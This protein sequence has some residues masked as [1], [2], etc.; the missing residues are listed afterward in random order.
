M[1][2]RRHQPRQQAAPARSSSPT[3]VFGAPGPH[4]HPAARVVHWQL[5]KRRAGTHKTKGISEVHGTTKK[6][7]TPE[8]HRPRPPR[9]RCA[10]RSSAAAAWSSA[11]SCAATRTTCRRRCA[12]SALQHARC[13]PRQA[14]G[15]LIVVDDATLGRAQD[16]GAGKRS[17]ASSAG[18]QRA[19]HRRRRGRRRTSRAPR[20]TSPTSTCCRSRAP[21]STTSCAATRWC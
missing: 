7:C 20:A 16:R 18:R 14:D 9:H 21:T 5:A 4:R 11:R 2:T 6:P 12:S 19:D 10:R 1:K 15:K 8:G 17:S 3:R 13:R